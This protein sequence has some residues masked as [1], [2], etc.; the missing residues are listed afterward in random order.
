[1]TVLNNAI[2]LQSDFIANPSSVTPESYHTQSQRKV[3]PCDLKEL[4]V[5]S[6]VLVEIR[7]KLAWRAPQ[8]VTLCI[9]LPLYGG[10]GWR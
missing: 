1:M 4:K 10:I 7:K 5:S 6:L 3:D 9:A 2:A 8:E